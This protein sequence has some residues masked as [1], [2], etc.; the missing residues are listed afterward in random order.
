MCVFTLAVF[1]GNGLRG[2]VCL[3]AYDRFYACLSTFLVELDHA[4]HIAVI[5]YCN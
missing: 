1:V 4:V 2:D 5:R 3:H